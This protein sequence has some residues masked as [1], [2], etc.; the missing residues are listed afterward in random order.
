MNYKVYLTALVTVETKEDKE[1]LDW[2]RE[3]PDDAKLAQI[4]FMY[5]DRQQRNLQEYHRVMGD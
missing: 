1:A 5:Q 4:K 2:F 3:L